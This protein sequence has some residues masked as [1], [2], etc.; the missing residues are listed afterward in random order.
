MLLVV[1]VVGARLGE[2]VHALAD[3]A[4]R[5]RPAL[6]PLHDAR[7]VVVDLRRDLGLAGDDQRRARLV[8]EDRVD[9]VHDREGVAALDGV[10]ERDGHVVAQVVE[11]ELGV[12]PVGD[13]GGVG[14]VARGLDGIMFS[15]APARMPSSS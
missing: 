9:L 7:E 13:V 4:R 11:A 1:E 8:D 6:E 10:L 15:M 12:R 14:L 5:R 3:A 2:L